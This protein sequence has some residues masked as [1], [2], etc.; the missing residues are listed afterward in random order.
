MKQITSA[1]FEAE[2]LKSAQPVLVDFYTNGCAPCRMMS[3]L[4][5]EMETEAKGAFKVVKI[6]AAT[7]SNLAAAFRVNAV[8]TF[9]AF[10]NGNCVGQATG[11]VSKARMSQWFQEAVH[12]A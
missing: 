3:P 7:E 6:D 12:K 10:T 8:P 11:A 2:V 5:Q 9:L 4:L 1:E